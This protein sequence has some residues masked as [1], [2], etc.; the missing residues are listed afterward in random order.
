M[1]DKLINLIY[2]SAKLWRYPVG[3]SYLFDYGKLADYLMAHGVTF[4]D[5]LEINVGN[6]GLV[7][8]A[9]INQTIKPKA[10]STLKAMKK[11][12]LI[13]YIR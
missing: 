11:A 1:R 6:K 2:D 10:D 7:D 9:A 3:N 13:D 4:A 8:L 12:D 5:V